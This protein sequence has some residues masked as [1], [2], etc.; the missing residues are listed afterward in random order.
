M[1]GTYD[2]EQQSVSNRIKGIAFR[3]AKDSGASFIDRMDLQRNLEHSI[4]A[5]TIGISQKCVK[6]A[7]TDLFQLTMTE[8]SDLLSFFAIVS[9]NESGP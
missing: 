8:L 4:E 2:T 5:L 6:A 1:K 7:F 3:E 9:V